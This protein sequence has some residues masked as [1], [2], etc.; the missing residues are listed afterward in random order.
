[1]MF[2]RVVLQWYDS[3]KCSDDQ[4]WPSPDMVTVA[5]T[6]VV[7]GMVKLGLVI[8]TETAPGLLLRSWPKTVT[9]SFQRGFPLH[10]GSESLHREPPPPSCQS[11]HC[12][13]S[14][15]FSCG[16]C[17]SSLPLG[18]VGDAWLLSALLRSSDG[19]C[20]ALSCGEMPA[21]DRSQ[22]PVITHQSSLISW[23]AHQLILSSSLQPLQS[24]FLFMTAMASCWPE[25]HTNRCSL[26]ISIL[27]CVSLDPCQ[28]ETVTL[29]KLLRQLY[30]V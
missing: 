8:T 7:T 9:T 29:F 28:R 12:C 20:S 26:V 19:S 27:T 21:D 3:D 22:C 15:Q 25:C 17:L 2:I 30:S 23:S 10:R 18:D 14:V 13:K 1:M 4:Y 11:P 24:Q 16:G 5:L 6:R